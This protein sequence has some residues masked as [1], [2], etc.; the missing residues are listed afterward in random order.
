MNFQDV[1]NLATVAGALA[2]VV[3]TWLL[4]HELRINNKLVRAANTQ[5]LVALSSPFTLSLI[6]D[7]A[8]AGLSLQGA[9][10]FN[11]LDT[12]DRYRYQCLLTWWLVYIENVYYQWRQ[13]LLDDMSYEPWATELSLFIQNHRLSA[14]W[15]ALRRQFQ[16]S[17]AHYVDHLIA[18][19]PPT[20]NG[21]AAAY[22][23]QGSLPATT[24]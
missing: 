3:S 17:F 23:A 6:Q 15:D 5:A 20:A 22:E 16:E 4:F 8:L 19:G 10:N 7:R 11:A 1:A 9:E 13:G 12:A 24:G 21:T 18:K 14:H 2:L